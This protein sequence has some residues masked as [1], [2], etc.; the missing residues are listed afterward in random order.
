VIRPSISSGLSRF[1]GRFPTG[2][3]PN[4]ILGVDQFFESFD[5]GFSLRVRAVICG[6]SRLMPIRIGT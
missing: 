4:L 5:R 3:V 6:P 1:V 2:F